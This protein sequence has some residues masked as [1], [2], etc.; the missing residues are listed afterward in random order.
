MLR[1]FDCVPCLVVTLFVR[2]SF[3]A[4]ALF[5]VSLSLKRA[6][7]QGK[8]EERRSIA[9]LKKSHGQGRKRNEPERRRIAAV[10]NSHIRTSK[11]RKKARTPNCRRTRKKPKRPAFLIR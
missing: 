10:Q 9:A 3:A 2:R 8:K 5:L 6:S 1:R 11:T 7:P 4:L